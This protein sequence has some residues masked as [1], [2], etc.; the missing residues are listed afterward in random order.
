[1]RALLVGGGGGGAD[2]PP[3]QP[4]SERLPSL[5]GSAASEWAQHPR[6]GGSPSHARLDYTT[7]ASDADGLLHASD[8]GDGGG[9]A[10]DEEDGVI[11]IGDDATQPIGAFFAARDRDRDGDR[12]GG[13]PRG[14]HRALGPPAAAAAAAAA[15]ASPGVRAVR[16]FQRHNRRFLLDYAKLK[17]G[18]F[19]ARGGTADVF[20]GVYC[21][22]PVAIKQCRPERMDEESVAHFHRENAV[23]V[24]LDGHPH[25]VRYYGLC[26]SPPHI[27]LVFELCPRDS[28]W[29]VL[30]RVAAA[31]AAWAAAAAAPTAAGA[32]PA[33][34][35]ASSGDSARYSMLASASPDDSIPRLWHKA[36][37]TANR[38]RRST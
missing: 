7:A 17:V 4:V 26:V 30:D 23:S 14:V 22:V 25:I 20:R 10:G 12:G 16:E 36:S 34:R 32:A 9:G 21:G 28:L 15:A 38:L 3:P 8:G 11:E 13:G 5:R 33:A 35:A 18:A 31:R 6:R 29:A 1:M 27:C 37:A 2:P 19:L 24:A